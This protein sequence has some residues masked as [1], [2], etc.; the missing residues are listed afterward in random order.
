MSKL[1]KK[2]KLNKSAKPFIPKG[3]VVQTFC[4][5]MNCN[6]SLKQDILAWENAV[7]AERKSI[8]MADPDVDMDVNKNKHKQ[9]FWAELAKTASLGFFKYM[10]TQ[11]EGIKDDIYCFNHVGS[12]V[13]KNKDLNLAVHVRENNYAPTE[14]H[15]LNYNSDIMYGY[16]SQG[17]LEDA[18]KFMS[19]CTDRE[20]RQRHEYFYESIYRAIVYRGDLELIKEYERKY[21]IPWK[22]QHMGYPGTLEAYFHFFP[23]GKDE[24]K[25]FKEH[26]DT[27]QR[28]LGSA[29]MKSLPLV[30]Y[31]L[32][33]KEIFTAEW[34]CDEMCSKTPE[35]YDELL[36]IILEEQKVRPKFVEGREV[37]KDE[38]LFWSFVRASNTY[39]VEMIDHLNDKYSFTYEKALEMQKVLELEKI[40]GTDKSAKI[41]AGHKEDMEEHRAQL[42]TL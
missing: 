1:E 41:L 28:V 19:L 40:H 17:R 35:L 15:R 12:T 2:S 22:F 39:N 4:S 8:V 5:V 3:E 10:E 32:G 38:F 26:D 23:E 18:I 7:K 13:A 29:T 6:D 16:A 42:A 11:R 25:T 36:K 34:A 21:P 30:K 14:F 33:K 31:I 37:S 9:A 27:Y 24:K 20:S